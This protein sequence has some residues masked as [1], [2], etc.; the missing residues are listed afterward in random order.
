MQYRLFLFR[1]AEPVGSIVFE[2]GNDDAAIEI[3]EAWRDGEAVELWNGARRVRCWG[4]P[5][6]HLA[7]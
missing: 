7:A 2:A 1:V 5:D 6:S 4:V 3:A